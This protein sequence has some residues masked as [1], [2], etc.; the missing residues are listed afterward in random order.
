MMSL[1]VRTKSQGFGTKVGWRLARVSEHL[2][3]GSTK[4]KS[5]ENRR[6]MQR[7]SV[8]MYIQR[9]EMRGMQS[10]ERMVMFGRGPCN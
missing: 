4:K 2:R 5:V 8:Y 6:D 3:W 9:A 10:R 1:R 7:S